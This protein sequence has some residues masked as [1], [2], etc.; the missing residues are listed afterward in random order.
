MNIYIALT[1]FTLVVLVYCAISEIFTM[2]FRFTGLPIEKAR[3]QVTSLLTGC[4]FTTQESEMFLSSRSRRKLARVTMLFGYVFNVTVVTAFINVFLSMNASAIM[5]GIVGATIPIGACVTLLILSRVPRVRSWGERQIER[6]A[7]R[8]IHHQTKNTVLLIDYI[9]KDVI[10]QITLHEVPEELAGR[11][12]AEA[13]IR[14]KYNV[15]VMLVDRGRHAVPA[16]GGTVF[17]EKDKLTV[18]G[19]YQTI[20]KLFRAAERFADNAD[21]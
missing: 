1:L 3:F 4:G 21:D 8:I 17:Q 2:R 5:S 9:G 11:T 7:D 18:F 20:C 6:I 14:T 19:N 16:A 15:L 12:L 10:A 13:D